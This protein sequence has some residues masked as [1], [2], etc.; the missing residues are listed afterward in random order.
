MLHA[1]S[2]LMRLLQGF[3]ETHLRG[4]YRWGEVQFHVTEEV[5]KLANGRRSPFGKFK[6]V[7]SVRFGDY[8]LTVESPNERPPLGLIMLTGPHGTVEENSL[9]DAVLDRFA[10]IIKAHHKETVSYV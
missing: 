7:V 1:R 4:L 5:E 10:D 8:D 3:F 2:Q 6:E 9:D